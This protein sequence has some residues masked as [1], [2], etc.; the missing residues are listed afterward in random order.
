[1]AF[2]ITFAQRKGGGGKTTLAAHLATAWAAL[3]RRVAVID[4]DPQ[5]SLTHWIELR[6]AAREGGEIGF[7]AMAVSGWKLGLELDRLR[8][9]HDIV[10][11]DSPPHADMDARVAIRASDLVVV[12][13]QP[14]P[15]DVW[16]TR[17]TLDLAR[18]ENR[19]A[20]LVLNRVA[21]RTRLTQEIAASLGQGDIRVAR[22]TLANRT[23]YAASL[24]V[25]A[26]VG[27][28]EPS[29]AAAGEITHLLAE[30]DDMLGAGQR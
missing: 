29:G 11:I 21:P 12:P 4:V 9:D 6:R 20:L 27:E 19:R 14:S 3:G 10:V 24:A 25:G 23:A 13:V 22:T 26:G 7:T 8:R 28:F 17:A 18:A 5:H 2:V 1:M 16:A 15:L 30:I